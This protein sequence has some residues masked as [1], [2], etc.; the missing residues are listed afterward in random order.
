MTRISQRFSDLR[1][2]GE[3]ALI[4]FITGGDP[5][6]L[7]T[8]PL[9]LEMEA[10]GADIV[11]IGVPFSDPLADGKSNQ[12]A[13]FRALE[14]GVRP[15]DVLEA[16]ARTR[17]VSNIPIVL[18]TYYNPIVRM[19][20]EKFASEASEAGVDGVIVT[21]LTPEEAGPWIASARQAALD[22]IFLLAPTST[23]ERIKQVCEICTGFVY[24]VSRTG[25]T[26]SQASLPPELGDLV[27]KIRSATDKP[28]VVG[29]GISNRNHVEEVC[30]LADGAVVG[31]ALVDFIHAKHQRDDFL[32]L[33]G[34]FV[35]DL[36]QGTK[37]AVEVT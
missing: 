10:A 22:T 25:V 1:S 11:E 24:C 18:M 13:Y 4:P 20:L 30:R 7:A 36:K 15:R 23:P 33:V 2:K 19:G 34:G 26:G 29:F 32:P 37:T 3:H 12:A 9:I 14:R 31:S 8:D 17:D 5:G 35:R 16:V 27:L 6:I 28:I 21:D